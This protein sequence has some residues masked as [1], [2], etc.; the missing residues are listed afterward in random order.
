MLCERTGRIIEHV[1]LS[2]TR[3]F[4]TRARVAIFLEM[5]YAFAIDGERE[6]AFNDIIKYLGYISD[7]RIHSNEKKKE[8][9]ENESG[10]S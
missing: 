9:K 6:G 8:K 4:E 3:K 1:S 2:S 7:S 5:P 10:F